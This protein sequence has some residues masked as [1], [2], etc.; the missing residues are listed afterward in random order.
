MVRIW[1]S[2]L[3]V[4]FWAKPLGNSLNSRL[5]I[6]YVRFSQPGWSRVALHL[7]VFQFSMWDSASTTS[8]KLSKSRSFN[9]LCEIHFFYFSWSKNDPPSFQFSMWDS[10]DFN[11][12]KP[13][14]HGYPFN[15]L[16]EIPL[17]ITVG[18]LFTIS[19]NSL[20]EIQGY[21][22]TRCGGWRC[23][24]FSMWDSSHQS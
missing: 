24:Q 1:L 14:Y 22:P 17:C 4:R 7:P 9:S 15:S 19:F 12:A 10:L 8:G 23:F 3:Y 21:E 18:S 13:S 5:S 20:C 16:C 11:Q 6:L 2:I